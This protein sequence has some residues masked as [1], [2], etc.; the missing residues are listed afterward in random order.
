MTGPA[1]DPAW[2]AAARTS[3]HPGV[4]QGP[5]LDIDALRRELVRHRAASGAAGRRAGAARRPPVPAKRAPVV[6][7]DAIAPAPDPPSP[8]VVSQSRRPR[9]AGPRIPRQAEPPADPDVDPDPPVDEVQAAPA[10]EDPLVLITRAKDGDAEA[11]GQLY[12]R[13]VDTVYRYVYYRVGNVALAEDLVSETF[14]RALRRFDTFTYQGRD[15]AAWFITIARNLIADHFK[16]ARFRLELATEDMV[17]TTGERPAEDDTE[18][19]VLESMTNRVLITAIKELNSE[20]QECVV[21]RFLQGLSVGETAEAMGKNDGA[22]KALQ[23]RAVKAL[24]RKLPPGS[25]F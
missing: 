24:A 21:L 1:R 25:T 13:N 14:L 6:E 7:S 20:Q 2:P 23:Y 22:V 3:A 18:A 4:H 19:Q 5:P 9:P 11:F 17:G 8:R 15:V 10:S 12:D 16:S